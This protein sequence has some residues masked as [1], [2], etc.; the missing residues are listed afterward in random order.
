MKGI[1][2]ERDESFVESSIDS[3]KNK[4]LLAESLLMVD[5]K[6]NFTKLFLSNSSS[7]LGRMDWI[8][9]KMIEKLNVVLSQKQEGYS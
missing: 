7:F 3:L 9:W 6:R 1:L 4:Q 5:L 2:T 8:W